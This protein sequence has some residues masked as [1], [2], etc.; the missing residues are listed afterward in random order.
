MDNFRHNKAK[1]HRFKTTDGFVG[2]NKQHGATDT[3][4]NQTLQPNQ[5]AML[6]DFHKRDGF[7]AAS[8]IAQ[9][10]KPLSPNRQLYGNNSR[11]N[12]DNLPPVAKP[13]KHRNWKKIIKRSSLALIVLT[14]LLGG[15]LFAKGY[16]K[17]HKVF[18]GGGGAIGLEENVDPTRLKGEGDG[19][20]NVLLLGIGGDGHEGPDLSDT[21]LIASIDPIQKTAALL[22][23]PRDLWVKPAGYG[24]MKIN[25]VYAN[26]KYSALAKKMNE[27]DAV[28]FGLSALDKEVEKDFGITMNYHALVDA[29]GFEQAINTVGGVDVN[30]DAASTVHEVLWDDIGNKT[31]TLDVKQG[32]QHFDGRRATFYAR[33]RHA[34]PR[35]DFDRTERQRLLILALKNK[36]FSLGTFSNPIKIS[37]LI[38]DFGDRISVNM[39]VNEMLRLYDLGKDIGNI[40]SLGLADPPNNFV[41]TDNINGISIVR[42]RA[43]LMD[44]SEIQNYV[45]NALKDGYIANEDAKVMV[46]NG[47]ETV[48]LASKK[49]DFLKSYGYNI[50]A[51]ADAPTKN[52]QKTILVDLRGGIKKYTK[53]YLEKRLGVKAVSKL[54]DINIAPGTADFVIILG[55]NEANNF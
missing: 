28:E 24:Y 21:I 16:W 26:N 55:Q 25:S 1:N 3:G 9:D 52:Y 12:M 13:K 39:K 34:S 46:L 47:T 38:D 29:R 49:A 11:S 20:V 22:S 5:N 27:K 44:F 18:R 40:A 43:G 32:Q 54:P 2:S 7:H 33:S 19:R 41:T 30:V 45:R 36:I 17:L 51:V 37:K 14:L 53:N 4:R 8:Q 15:F 6:G 23:I 50:S 31:Y 35:G 42:P 48:G 10:T